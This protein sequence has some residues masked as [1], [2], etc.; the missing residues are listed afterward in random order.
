MDNIY[1]FEIKKKK[2]LDGFVVMFFVFYIYFWRWFFNFLS[3]K[4][5]LN[6]KYKNFE[7]DIVLVYVLMLYE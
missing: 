7:I 6:L 3:I 4:Y 5:Y 1:Y 2:F